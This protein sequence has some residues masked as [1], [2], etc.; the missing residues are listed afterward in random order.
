[1]PSK[2]YS[3]K[4]EREINYRKMWVSNGSWC[5]IIPDHYNNALDTYLEMYAVAKLDFP[6]LQLSDVKC[7]VVTKSIWCLHMPILSFQI[8][9]GCCPEGYHEYKSDADFYAP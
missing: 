1:M 7:S 4:A 9:A 8:K 5:F 2:V 6:K 3:T